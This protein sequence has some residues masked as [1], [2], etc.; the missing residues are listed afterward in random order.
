[1][2]VDAIDYNPETDLK[3]LF[4]VTTRD[5]RAEIADDERE[6][7]AVI[8]SLGGD[9]HKYRRERQRAVKRVVSEIYSPPRVAAAIKLLPELRLIPGF[10]LDLTTADSD[11]CLWDFDSTT[12]RDRV[13]KRIREEGSMLLVGSPMCTAFSTWQGISNF[14]RDPLTVEA[15]KKRAVTHL[16]FCMELY[17]EQM[18]HGRYFLHKH[19]AYAT[20]WQG[21][22]VRD[23]LAEACVV[24][25]TRGHSLSLLIQ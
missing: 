24:T 2:D 4:S 23:L 14:I 1:M 18:K 19:P 3:E 12:M 15:E 9:G 7:I 13:L 11:G 22:A 16:E 6:I 21:T 20:S 10:S 5:T 25:A 8:R 17:R